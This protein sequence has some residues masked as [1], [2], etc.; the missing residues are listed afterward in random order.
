[1]TSLEVGYRWLGGGGRGLE[2]CDDKKALMYL[3]ALSFWN[4]LLG[5][6]RGREVNVIMI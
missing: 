3:S 4:N 6:F 1:M 5:K 2:H